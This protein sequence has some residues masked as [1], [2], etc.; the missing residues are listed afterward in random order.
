VIFKPSHEVIIIVDSTKIYDAR[1]SNIHC[2]RS[3]SY[4]LRC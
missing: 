4:L 2:G 3:Y 1:E